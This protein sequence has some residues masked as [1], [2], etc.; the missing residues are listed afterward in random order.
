MVRPEEGWR[1]ALGDARVLVSGFGKWGGGLYDATEAVPVAID[2]L[3]SSG[4]ALGGGRLWRLLRAPGEQTSSCELLAY[5]ARGVRSYR[6]FD[7]IRDPHDVVW[8]DGA[9]HVSASWDD[10]VWRIDPGADE[11]RMVWQGSQVPDAWHVNS[12]VVVDGA[13]HVC[14]FGRGDRHKGWKTDTGEPTG[15]VY[16]LRAGRDVLTGLA[17]PHTP[18]RR[19]DRWYVC[20]STTGTLTELDPGGEVLRRAAVRRFTR[21]L[22]FVDRWALV[23]GNAHREHDDD[24]AEVVVVD[25]A[26]FAVVARI[27]MPCLEVYDILVVPPTV[28]R[29]A[30][31]G[32]GAN[33][34]RAVEQHRSPERPPDRRPAPP[35]AGVRLVTERT[36]ATLA[37]AGTPLDAGTARGLAVRGTLPAQAVA[38]EVTCVTVEVVNRTDVPLASVLPRPV[39]VGARWRRTT[40]DDRAAVANPLVPLPRV[41]PPAMRTPLDVPL[42]VPSE[43]GT[44]EVRV[45]LRQPGLGWLGVRLQS[46]VV[47]VAGDSVALGPE[48]GEQHDV[49]DAVG[50][51]EQHDEPVHADA[52]PAGGR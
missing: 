10:A 43:P 45:A 7:T 52:E 42:E 29:G 24:R 15:F 31:A 37:T 32:F 36:A 49:A 35:E 14:G 34:A 17:H 22:T 51:G 9:P 20:E 44:Y 48:G 47:V 33:A 3:P 25:L 38:G 21:G 4:L 28:V 5:D 6:R 39:K 12:L 1:A 23:G 50:V 41:L 30:A 11:P 2:D 16:D 18:R 27:P 19:G 46:E 13:L 8:F 40:G 26:G